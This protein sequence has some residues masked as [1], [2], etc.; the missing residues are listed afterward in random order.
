MAQHANG[1]ECLLSDCIVCAGDRIEPTI[2]PNRPTPI[3]LRRDALLNGL[4]GLA[5][6]RRDPRGYR[7]LQP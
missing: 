7:A 2:R 3:T 6:P 1:F 5:F 4:D